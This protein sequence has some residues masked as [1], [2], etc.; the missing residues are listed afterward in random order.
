MAVPVDSRSWLNYSELYVI[1]DTT[2]WGLSSVPTVSPAPDDLLY[3]LQM[4]DR[5]D[6][7]SFQFYRDPRYEW[8]IKR[9]NDIRIWPLDAHPGTTIRIPRISRMISEGIIVT[10]S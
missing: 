9:V 1:G 4:H 8:I 7:L 3:E 10:G 6:N 2:F 5:I